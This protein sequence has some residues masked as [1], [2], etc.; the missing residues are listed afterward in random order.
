MILITYLVKESTELISII[1]ANAKSGLFEQ[2][3]CYVKTLP[4]EKLLNINF[5]EDPKFKVENIYK[6]L[7][8]YTN[9]MC[10]IANPQH[11]ITS[12]TSINNY[13]QCCGHKTCWTFGPNIILDTSY[14]IDKQFIN[15]LTQTKS[16]DDIYKTSKFKVLDISDYISY[17]NKI[18]SEEIKNFTPQ[19][20]EKIILTS[21]DLVKL[22]NINV[23]CINLNRA[24][25]RRL[26]ILNFFNDYPNF[27]LINAIDGN[28]ID[29]CEYKYPKTTKKSIY[30]IATNF[31]HLTAIKAAYDKGL[32]MCLIMED[33]IDLNLITRWDF[34]L[35]FLLTNSPPDWEILQLYTN[36]P[37]LMIKLHDL[38][39]QNRSLW[40]RWN[41]S[42]WSAGFYIIKRSGM[43]KILN[44]YWITN[45]FDL[46]KFDHDGNFLVA[47]YIIYAEC[48]TYILNKPIIHDDAFNSYIHTD[49]VNEY[50]VKSKNFVTKLYEDKS[51][52]I[53]RHD[54]YIDEHLVY[55]NGFW[56][57]FDNKTDGVHIGLLE[58]LFAG[59]KLENFKV[60]TN[61]QEA[62]VLIESVLSNQSFAQIK[63]WKY[64]IQL[65]G[66]SRIFDNHNYN[67]VL[68]SDNQRENIITFPFG[69]QFIHTNNFVDKLVNR[70]IVTTIPKHFC[71]WI[72][73]NPHCEIRNKIFNKLSEYKKVHSYGSY[74]NNMGFSLK[75]PYWSENYQKFMSNYKFVI[76]FE[77]RQF[78]SYITEKIINPFISKSIPIYWGTNYVNKIFNSNAF[79]YLE[80]ESEISLNKLIT[81]II[82]LD[83]ND[84]LYLKMLN[85]P[86]ISN[87]DE[88]NKY[89]PEIIN[90]QIKYIL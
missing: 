32:E 85:E 84:E 10:I 40:S 74:L 87:I 88:F 68:S 1:E 64:K 60:T 72:V 56:K 82:E 30:E 17:E 48:K 62:N 23:N 59:T 46:N 33:D 70:T 78:E 51:I 7:S 12:F 26:R 63:S 25:D 8:Q 18:E 6:M 20:K 28:F 22:S 58:K 16:L 41:G 4:K 42:A 73:S 65:S 31:S 54:E 34:D 79:L 37:N 61:I 80:D 50:H 47:D 27:N 52:A 44:K 11:L 24:T 21:T 90:Q 29:G 76:C 35:N 19:T 36:N 14:Y 45:R 75:F 13:I 83:T 66:E 3:C 38:F 15:K 43:E 89:R 71:C 81:R 2:V 49:H 67:I 86:V 77:N 57:G 55:L 69:F 5:I 39:N 9:K 53:L